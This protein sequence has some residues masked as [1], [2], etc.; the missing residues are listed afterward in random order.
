MCQSPEGKN[1][2]ER[3]ICLWCEMAAEQK[4]VPL[5]GG[6]WGREANEKV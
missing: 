4:N 2:L 6:E 1:V 3:G 5:Q